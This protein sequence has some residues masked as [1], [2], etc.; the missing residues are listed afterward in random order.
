MQ[1]RERWRTRKAPLG[2]QILASRG[3]RNNPEEVIP[4]QLDQIESIKE[5]GFIVMPVTDALERG[6]PIVIASNRLSI[7]NAGAHVQGGQSA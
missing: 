6:D 2:F 7:D 5:N 4:V 1:D 3:G